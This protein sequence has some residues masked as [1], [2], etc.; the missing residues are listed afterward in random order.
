MRKGKEERKKEDGGRG[1]RGRKRGKKEN[2]S[3][4]GDNGKIIKI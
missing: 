3:R 1:K 2:K 4:G